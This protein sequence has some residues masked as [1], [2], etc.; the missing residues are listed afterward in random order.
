M[1][2]KEK[3][4]ISAESA[5]E[6]LNQL[7]VTGTSERGITAAE[8]F[9]ILESADGSMM[10]D[11]SSEYF[12]FDKHG[13]YHF[14]VESI[15]TALIQEKQIEVVRMKDRE[16]NNLMNG[17]KLF[18]NGCKR[19]EQLPAYVRV[20]YTGDVKNKVGSYKTLVVKTFPVIK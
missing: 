9:D 20:Y 14:V 11:L 16:G 2:T 4:S 10:Q 13:E 12:K 5:N 15:D 17:D 7:A 18:V 3:I 6:A 8:A 19:L 1:A